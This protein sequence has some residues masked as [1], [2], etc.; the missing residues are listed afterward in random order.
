MK[1]NLR[2]LCQAELLLQWLPMQKQ[3]PGCVR[4][5]VGVRHDLAY[6]VNLLCHVLDVI[7][8]LCHVGV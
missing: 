3:L 8:Q 2:T 5:F 6:S 7:G 1:A 4:A